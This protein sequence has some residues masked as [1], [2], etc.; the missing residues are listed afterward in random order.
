MKVEI[1]EKKVILDEFFEVHKG[2]LRFERFDGLMSPVVTRYSFHKNDAVAV[3]LYHTTE[4]AYVLVRQMRFPPFIQEVDPWLVEIVAGGISAGEDSTAA[5]LREVE[6]E[7]G[8]RPKHIERLMQFYVSPG[9]MSERI[10]LFFA[11]I[12]EDCKVHIGGGAAHEDEDTEVVRI[13]RRNAMQWV[14]S[15]E[16][17]DAKTILALQWHALHGK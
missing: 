15:Q 9:I 7:T 1:L 3:L 10:T 4:D 16:Y 11:E 6:E 2:K 13:P 14:A 5:A 17:G 8:Y 12:D